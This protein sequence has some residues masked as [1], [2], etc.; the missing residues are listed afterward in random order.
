MK[1][2]C[3]IV[4]PTY[5]A[6]SDF[7]AN[8]MFRSRLQGVVFSWRVDMEDENEPQICCIIKDN[9]CSSQDIILHIACKG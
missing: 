6:T 4:K 2:K 1:I 8:L 7:T 3:L 5:A 9:N